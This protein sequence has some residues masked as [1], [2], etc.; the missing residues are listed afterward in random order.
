MLSYA[1]FTSRVIHTR[2]TA[3][4]NATMIEPIMLRLANARAFFFPNQ[5]A[6]DDAAKNA[7]D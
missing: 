7:K 5:P 6:T 4:T 3:P 1:F 2:S